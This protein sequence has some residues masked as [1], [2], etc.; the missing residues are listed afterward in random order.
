MSVNI[1][2]I[3]FTIDNSLC[4]LWQYDNA[5][6]LQSLMKSKDNFLTVNVSNFWENYFTDIFNIATANSFGL[7]VWGVILGVARP[8][9]TNADNQTV[10]FTDDMY[11][12]ILLASVL[13]FNSNSSVASFNDYFHFIFNNKSVFLRNNYDMTV[14]IVFYYEPTIEDMAVIA[15]PYFLPLPTGV[16]VNYVI[17][18]QNTIFGFNGSGLTGFDTG[19]FIE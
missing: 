3:N 4:Y 12:K 2:T 5:K 15:S 18:P 19:T 13:K 11:R 7:E 6:N 1:G 14:D 16:G 9:Y 8:Q 10:P 17:I